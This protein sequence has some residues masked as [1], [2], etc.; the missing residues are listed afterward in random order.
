[1]QYILNLSL[2]CF[3]SSFCSC[4]IDRPLNAHFVISTCYPICNISFA[5][6]LQIYLPT[7]S[8]FLTVEEKSCAEN[9]IL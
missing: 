4:I 3:M 2:V 7:S 9:K 1:M 6:N 8:L 5:I